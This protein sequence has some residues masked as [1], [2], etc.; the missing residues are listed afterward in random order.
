MK[1]TAMKKGYF[2]T[3]TLACLVLGA[4]AT[5][6]LAADS[7]LDTIRSLDAAQGR[8]TVTTPDEQDIELQAPEKFFKNLQ[9][10]DGVEITIAHGAVTAIQP[11]GVVKSDDSLESEPEL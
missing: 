7:F 10:G 2:K 6:T 3:V 9:I 8:F 11:A 5:L 4:S 1:G